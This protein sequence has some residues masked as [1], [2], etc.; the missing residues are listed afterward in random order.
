MRFN[1]ELPIE[2]A[3]K[4]FHN[5]VF[6]EIFD[7]FVNNV[8]ALSGDTLLRHVASVMGERHDF[9]P[10]DYKY[11]LE[12]L[13]DDDFY[14]CLLAV[15]GIYTAHTEEALYAAQP[16]DREDHNISA[17]I[18]SLDI[19]RILDLSEVELGIAWKPPHFIPTGAKLLD[20]RLVNDSLEWL[21]GSRYEPVYKPFDKGLSHFLEASD[22]PQLLL[23]VITDMYEAL[24]A[25]AKVMVGNNK[26]LSANRE[27]FVNELP[28]SEK[29]KRLLK[30]YVAYANDFR[31]GDS[32]NQPRSEPAHAEVESFVYLTG[33]FI[34]L[35]VESTPDQ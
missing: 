32:Q 2:D 20:D 25:M 16:D 30:E 27:R 12:S 4:R 3:Q 35:A 22:K 14:R 7:K 21:S 33:L 23:D 34:R 1:I 9:M 8:S 10:D 11:V 24:E 26:D 28:V 17:G 31:H 15:E 19:Q 18:L 13:V 29:Y 6:N 5:R